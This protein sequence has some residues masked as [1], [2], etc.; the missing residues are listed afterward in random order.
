[1]ITIIQDFTAF[2]NE[3]DPDAGINH[4]NWATCVVGEYMRDRGINGCPSDFAYATL[5][6]AIQQLCGGETYLWVQIAYGTDLPTY[7]SLA[8][9]LAIEQKVTVTLD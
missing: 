9:A 6:P 8:D 7:G 3:R 4:Y 5:I 2:V 1:M